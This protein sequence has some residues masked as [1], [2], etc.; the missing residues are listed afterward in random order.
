MHYSDFL[1]SADGKLRDWATIFFAYL[2]IR[3]GKFN[4][5]QSDY[6]PVHDAFVDFEA[7]LARAEDP[8]THTPGAVLAKNQARKVFEKALRPFIKAWI[9]FNPSVTDEDRLNMGLT[10]HKDHS[11]PVPDPTTF[12]EAMVVLPAAGIVQIHFRDQ[13]ADSKAKPF[14]VH[15]CEVGWAVLETEPE[16]WDDLNHS[17]FDTH[18]PINLTFSGHD[19]GK[20]LYFALRWE[21][22][23]G[24]KGPWSIIQSAI[25]P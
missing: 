7:K 23:R 3:L 9:A 10:V 16:D 17:S 14:G 1:P 15:G 5:P 24:V 25:I 19:R 13:D 20:N 22:T 4:V 12:P 21:N 8:E 11:T 2:I 6:T 18:T